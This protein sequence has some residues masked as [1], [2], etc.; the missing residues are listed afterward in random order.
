LTPGSVDRR[1]RRLRNEE[2][3]IE[4]SSNG[5]SLNLAELGPADVRSRI[6]R[7]ADTVVL[8]LGSCER[9]GN[10][11]TPIGLDGIIAEALVERATAKAGVLHAPLVPFGYAPM[12]VGPLG[13]G[14]GAITLRGE[15]LRRLAEDAARSL[16][17]Q[18]FD[19][20]VFV[21]LHSPN[22]DCLDEVLLSLRQRTGAFVAI[23]GGRES[24]AVGE[25]FESSPARLTS[26]VEASMAMALVGERFR[27][28]DY[29]SRSYDIHA[30]EWLGDGFSKGSGTGS[31]VAF[32]GASNIRLGMEDYEYTSRSAQPPQP[33]DATPERGER[34]LDSLAEHLAAFLTQ[35]GELE[36][37]VRE[38]DF[39]DRAR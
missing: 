17:Y 4:S 23:Y 25:I 38:R 29:L 18:G 10:P 26:D 19:K 16:L 24:S 8:P 39:P 5:R 32:D 15:T 11:F 9:H 27:G 37:H 2:G 12:H 35:V 22:I 21:T 34:L 14:C 3:I 13:D 1:L 30:P 36:V 20:V 7:G 31:A 6:D 28:D 33:S